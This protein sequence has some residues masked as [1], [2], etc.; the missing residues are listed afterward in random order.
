M[1]GLIGFFDILGYQNFLKNNSAEQSI[2]KVFDIITSMPKIISDYSENWSKSIENH[3]IFSKFSKKY[4]NEFSLTRKHLV[5]SDTIVFTLPLPSF[6]FPRYNF[7]IFMLGMF[8][9]K[10]C[11]SLLINEMHNHGL[12]IRGVLHEGDFFLKDSCLAG[13]GIVEAYQLCELLNF[14]GL[15]CSKT[16]SDTF[17]QRCNSETTLINNNGDSL[18]AFS[19]PAPLK[20][21]GDLNLVH[22]NWMEVILGIKENIHY[23]DNCRDDVENYV[24]KSFWDHQKECPSS[25][26]LKVHNTAKLIRKMLLNIDLKENLKIVNNG[27]EETNINNVIA[28]KEDYIAAE[29]FFR[30]IFEWVRASGFILTPLKKFFP[31]RKEKDWFMFLN[32]TD[33]FELIT[34]I[35]DEMPELGLVCVTSKKGII[36][37]PELRP[38]FEKKLIEFKINYNAFSNLSPS[39][40]EE[41]IKKFIHVQSNKISTK[42]KRY[43][44]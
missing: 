32:T 4:A 22:V 23:F 9:M 28:K 8:H 1:K 12:P 18:F 40:Q 35:E 44:K 30:D 2:N 3:E 31:I 15:V 42:A 27:E 13:S 38:D 39:Y 6:H 7:E 14:S 41:I 33:D 10:M 20:N 16:L 17:I 5:F 25:V 34:R 29:K 26:D 19:Y 36:V 11:S 43:K 21:G 24:L 37:E